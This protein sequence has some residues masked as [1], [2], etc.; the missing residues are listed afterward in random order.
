MA[1][2]VWLRNPDVAVVAS[3]GRVVVLDLTTPQTARPFAMEGP[4]HA[5]WQALDDRPTTD[6]V[7]ER[8]AADFGIPAA[9]VEPDVRAFLAEL[10][11]RGLATTSP[12]GTG[13]T[14]ADPD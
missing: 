14:E 12:V 11:T 1:D 2:T 10:A 8:V 5:I 3:P 13:D 6:Q 4:A 7:I 9:E